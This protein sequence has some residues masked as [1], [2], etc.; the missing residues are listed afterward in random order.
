MCPH[1]QVFVKLNQAVD[2]I[3][4]SIVLWNFGMVGVL[5]I[6]WRSPLRLTQ[7]Y[8]IATS[9]LMVCAAL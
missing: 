2:Y 7:A 4:A 3:T 5:A 1:R 9:A 8:L 6:H